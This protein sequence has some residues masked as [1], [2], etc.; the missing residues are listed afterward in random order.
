[1]RIVDERRDAVLLRSRT[2]KCSRGS[3]SFLARST[4]REVTRLK[5]VRDI[6]LSAS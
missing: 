5:V 3:P 2:V 1:M 4:T 6:G